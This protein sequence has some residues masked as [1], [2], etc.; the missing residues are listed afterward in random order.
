MAQFDEKTISSLPPAVGMARR[1]FVKGLGGLALLAGTARRACAQPA[2]G[3]GAR[4][5]AAP[6]TVE[7]NPS[8][9]GAADLWSFT[10]DAAG[11]RLR[12]P[13]GEPLA[14]RLTN[15]LP[16]P[17]SMHI[18]G[19]RVDNALDG[20]APLAGDAVPP[21]AERTLTLTPARPGTFLLR[22]A[23]LAH[24]AEQSARGLYGTL[25]VPETELIAVDEDVTVVLSDWALEE[26]GALRASFGTA[27]DAGFAGRLGNWLTVNGVT[28]PQAVT[29]PQRGRARLRLVNAANARIF[30]LRF[31]AMEAEVIAVDSIATE[32][33]APARATLTLLP[34]AR[35]DVVV[36]PGEGAAV[37][38]LFGTSA[39]PLVTFA[40]TRAPSPHADAPRP[41][42]PAPDLPAAI[43]LAAALRAEAVISGGL[44]PARPATD[45]D[46]TRLWQVNG[47]AFTDQREPLLRVPRG[48]PAVLAFTN[49]TAFVQALHI[50]GHHV[51]LLHPLDDGWEPYWLDTFAV[52]PGRTVRIAF[53]ADNPGRW[54]IGSAILDRLPAGLATWYEVT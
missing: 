52:P 38:G 46:V 16:Q 36:T 18:L 10:G 20:A 2:A 35:L 12:A 8:A 23:T 24:A 30:T 48:R 28:P 40:A 42:L 13:L 6:A 31:D 22:P 50:H 21:G 11:A 17:V 5:A 41:A 33:F 43:D 51:R 45:A 37:S 9:A 25:V 26:S 34:G 27:E 47:A 1:T 44:D 3:G 4:L 7:L 19:L 54:L 53:V 29:L 15:G 49:E 32:P 14:L 39:V